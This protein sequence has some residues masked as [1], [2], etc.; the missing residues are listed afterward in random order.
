[1][2]KYSSQ[3]KT[4]LWQKIILI[5]CGLSSFFTFILISEFALRCYVK[6]MRQKAVISSSWIPNEVKFAILTENYLEPDPLLYWRLRTKDR[7]VAVNSLHT[8]GEEFSKRK[9]PGV[10]RIVC[11]G[12]SSTYGAFINNDADTYCKVLEK[13]L[14]SVLN[15]NIRCEVINAGV[16]G[17]GTFQALSYLQKIIVTWHPDLVTVYIGVNNDYNITRYFNIEPR[18]KQPLIMRVNDFFEHSYAYDFL[19]SCFLKIKIYF[20]NKFDKDFVFKYH[21]T[22]YELMKI[23]FLRMVNIAKGNGFK[24][25]FLNYPV[26]EFNGHL[27]Y[28]NLGHDSEA[29]QAIAIAAYE[30]NVPFVDIIKPLQAA[31]GK[32]LFFDVVHPTVAG[33]KIIAQTIFETLLTKEIISKE[34]FRLGDVNTLPDKLSY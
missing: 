26:L 3:P 4:L 6:T 5:L 2:H 32:A 23:H 13:M 12:D 15:Q 7:K 27:D 34:D 20:V 25:V 14:N 16:P 21:Q 22:S 33:H 18:I 24:I 30:A 31:G 29:N 11:I 10:F 9:N 1:M 28:E 19:K 17:Y 8:R